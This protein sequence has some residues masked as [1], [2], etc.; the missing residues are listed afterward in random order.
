MSKLLAGRKFS[1]FAQVVAY[2]YQ[3]PKLSI[4]SLA[5][6]LQTAVCIHAASYTGKFH[7]CFVSN[8]GQHTSSLT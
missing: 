1:I 8:K 6:G 5:H 4:F 7:R 2:Q 3:Q